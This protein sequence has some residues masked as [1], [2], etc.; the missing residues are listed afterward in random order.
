MS[1]IGLAQAQ[2]TPRLSAD[3][4]AKTFAFSSDEKQPPASPPVAQPHSYREL[5]NR[6]TPSVVSVFPER[7][8]TANDDEEDALSRFFKRESSGPEN[9]DGGDD[10]DEKKEQEERMGLGSGVILSTDGWIV[11]NSHVVHLVN[12][13]LADSASVELHNRRIYKAKIVGADP[14]TDL[15]LLKVEAD[16][17]IPIEIGDS[18]WVATGDL[19]FAVGNPF[20][21]GMTATM[22]MVSATQRTTL[23]LNG[24]GGYESFI[25]TDASI[26]PGNSGGALVDAHGRLIGINTAIYNTGAGNI[27]IG[28]AIPTRLMTEVVKDLAESGTISRGFFGIHTEEVTQELADKAGSTKIAGATVADIM[29]G[30]PSATAGIEQ[31]DIITHADGREMSNKGSLRVAFSCVQPGETIELTIVRSGAVKKFQVT[32]S[33][34]PS[35]TAAQP[36]KD[37]SLFTLDP[38][39]GV[40]FKINDQGLEVVEVDESKVNQAGDKLNVGMIIISINGQPIKSAADALNLLRN[41]VNKVVTQQNGVRRT[42][43][44]RT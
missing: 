17:L 37:Q 25:Q 5:I 20:K 38:I 8:V 35:T 22:G 2:E 42:L 3:Q 40:K 28:F 9:E 19:V 41:G 18:D 29:L 32:A 24:P 44:L 43:A 39:A 14:L 23:N 27:G 21:L 1:T 33:T 4:A 15:A 36:E 16:N 10:D 7:L 34:S 31:G 11:T 6:V 13:R 30:G 26:N 12:G